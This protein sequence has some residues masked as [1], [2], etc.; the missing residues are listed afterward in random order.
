MRDPHEDPQNEY[1]RALYVYGLECARYACWK[2][3][4][5]LTDPVEDPLGGWLGFCADHI[6][7]SPYAMVLE[8]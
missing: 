3:I 7:N 4:M 5:F 6:G 1:E 8:T 2:P